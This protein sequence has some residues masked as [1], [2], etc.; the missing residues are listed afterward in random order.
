MDPK[1][2][3]HI[4]PFLTKPAEPFLVPKCSHTYII[5]SF[6]PHPPTDSLH[7]PQGDQKASLKGRNMSVP[8]RTKS[9]PASPH[10]ATFCIFFFLFVH[11][12]IKIF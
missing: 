1:V 3:F 5:L 4:P 9:T 12:P 7:F 11:F 8:A 2:S 10:P 6:I